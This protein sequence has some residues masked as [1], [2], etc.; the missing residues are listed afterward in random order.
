MNAGP[1]PLPPGARLQRDP[2]AAIA[3]P[4]APIAL[5][6]RYRLLVGALWRLSRSR[7]GRW[8]LS[9]GSGAVVVA[10]ALL[11]ARHF[12]TTSWPLANG[13]PGVLAAAG[14]LFLLAQA[15]KA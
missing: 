12:A 2:L 7:K 13:N 14:V 8:A 5:E 10:L 11:A 15:L 6:G 4:L 1:T 9:I 3:V